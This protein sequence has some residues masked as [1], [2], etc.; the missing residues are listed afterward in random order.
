MRWAKKFDIPL[1]HQILT[2]YDDESNV[3]VENFE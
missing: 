2:F 3:A 1:S